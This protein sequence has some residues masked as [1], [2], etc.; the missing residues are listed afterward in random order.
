MAEVGRPRIV[1]SPEE[2]DQKVDEYRDLCR[3]KEEPVT[4]TGMALHLGFCD[5]R[6]LYDYENYD[7]F[8]RSVKRA[9]A[10][11]EWEYEKR[12]AGNNVAGAIFAL[13]NHGWSDLQQISGPNEGPIQMEAH[14]VRRRLTSRMAGLR[15]RMGTASPSTNG[16]G[17]HAP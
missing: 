8:S 11:V 16:N 5:R 12:L 1:A 2:F 13:K 7:G 6:S 14:D 9:R 4:F 17:T 15:S 3:A 10:L